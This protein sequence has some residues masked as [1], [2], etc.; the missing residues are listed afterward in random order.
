MVKSSR[1]TRL[2]V[3]AA[4]VGALLALAPARAEDASATAAYKDIEATLG[5]VPDMF[6][7]LP[8]V[9][10]AGAW[11]EIKSMQLNPKTALDGK[12]KEFIGL[13]VASQIPCQYCVYFHTEAAK[14]NG[15]TDEE[16]KE[17]VAMAAIVR[18]W[19]TMLNGSQVDLTAFKKQTDDV[20]AA[21]KAKSQ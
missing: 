9:A 21:V 20:F 10:V 17:A 1:K 13:A 2:L 16:I 18:H 4:G 5:S 7:T 8:D 3:I 15:A 6:R 19:S 11:A 14:L 12:T